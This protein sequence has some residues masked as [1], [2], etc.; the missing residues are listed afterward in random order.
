MAQ[1]K[2]E[3]DERN[4][5]LNSLADQCFLNTA[6]NEYI[7]AR[8]CYR[9]GLALQFNWSALHCLEKYLKAVLLYNRVPARNI[10]HEP[11]KLAR[12]ALTLDFCDI[13]RGSLKFMND[14]EKYG[15]DRYLTRSY[16]MLWNALPM[17]DRS[18][19]EVRK[20]CR[21]LSAQASRT[22]SDAKDEIDSAIR[23]LSQADPRNPEP[24]PL[25]GARLEGLIDGEDSNERRALIWKNL[26]FG[27]KLRKKVTLPVRWRLENSPG[28]LYPDIIPEA[29]KYIFWPD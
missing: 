16:Q 17:L 4:A 20:Y 12:K 8:M 23:R 27:K 24:F 15:G 11:L 13:S 3:A 14:L 1:F 9:A 5:K 10:R 22:R 7:V 28:F 2:D 19:W 29:R 18:V 6:D 21:V 25:A 26:F